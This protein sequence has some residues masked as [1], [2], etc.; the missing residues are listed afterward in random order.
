MADDSAYSRDAAVTTE[1]FN[2]VAWS[3][4]E[5]LKREMQNH[6]EILNPHRPFIAFEI[7]KTK[8]ILNILNKVMNQFKNQVG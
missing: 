7:D 3:A 4:G 5:Q 8:K 1:E 2:E 6:P